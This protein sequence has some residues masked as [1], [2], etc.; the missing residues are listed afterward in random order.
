MLAESLLIFAASSSSTTS[1]TTSYVSASSSSP[2]SSCLEIVSRSRHGF[3]VSNVD[4]FH[5]HKS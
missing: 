4:G 1:S 2:P 5:S 3:L